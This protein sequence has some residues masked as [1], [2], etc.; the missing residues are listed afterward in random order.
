MKKRPIRFAKSPLAAGIATALFALS[1]APAQ[2]ATFNFGDVEVVFDSTFSYGASW[3]TEERNWDTIAKV[4]HPRFNWTGYNAATNV[5]YTPSEIW[6]RPGA[7]SSNGDAGNLN[8]D[9]GDMFSSM[10]KGLH[11]L[12]I[13]KDN[14]GFFSRFMYFYDTAMNRGSFAYTNPLSGNKVDPCDD[15]RSRELACK[16]IRLLDAFVYGNFSFN[17]GMNPVTIRVGNQVLSW[18]ESTFIPHGINIT[19]VDVG[20]LRA[21][22]AD[23]K[24]AFIPTGMVTLAVGLTDQLSAEL[25]YQYSWQESYLPPPGT[26]FSTNDFAGRGGYAQNIQLGFS[27][28]PD[29]DLAHL[30]TSLNIF[31]NQVAAGMDQAQQIAQYLRFPQKVALRPFGDAGEIKPKNGGQYGIKFEYFA[32]NLGDTEF[33]T[34]YMNY[35]SRVPVI[36]GIASDFRFAAVGRD[37]AFLGQN[38]GAINKDNINNLAAFSKGLLEYPEDIK[39]YGFSFNTNLGTTSVAGEIAYRQDEPLQIDDVE[40][41]YAGMP[42]QLA[43]SDIPSVVNAASAL[44]GISQLGRFIGTKA[45][46]G[47]YAQGYILRNT[48]QAQATV[49]HLFGPTLGA[50]NFTMLAEVGGVRINNMPT[51]DVL[52]LNGPNTDRS[53]APLIGANGPSQGLHTNLS[54]GPETNPFP[55]ASAW[56][57]RVLAKADYNNVFAGVNLSQRLV[58]SHDVNGITPDPLFMFVKDRKSASYA[59]SFDYLNKWSGELSYN[60]FWG[61]VGTTNNTADRDFISFN[62]KYSI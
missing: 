19:P 18:G 8:F 58:F 15:K 28:N 30:L 60:W 21:P 31:S 22:G 6:L 55:T 25:F 10:F 27:G 48:I 46:P 37:L 50:D 32:P 13:K 12:S 53:G 54:N 3:R 62:I 24:E 39:L 1:Y 57:Y 23:L 59:V 38:A 49:T 17:D 7:Y 14:I 45:T 61:G 36:S 33:A 9:R 35:H 11:E 43:N 29:I 47:N 40:I 44:S 20:I 52:R 34:Y 41:L 4:N 26:Y 2:A 42:E 51:Q 56:G 16:D 5:I